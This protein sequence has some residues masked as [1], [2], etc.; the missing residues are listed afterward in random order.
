MLPKVAIFLSILLLSSTITNSYAFSINGLE[1]GNNSQN[2][3]IS[4]SDIMSIEPNF[5][6]ENNFKRYLIFG[7]NLEQNSILK[8][9]SLYGVTSDH[10]FFSV[11][12]LSEQ[13]ASNLITKGYTVIED[14][15]LDFH[16]SN[17][18]SP[19]VSRI[20][21]ITGS[22]N[23]K[24]KYNA[25]GKDIVIAIVDTGVDFSNPDIQHSLAR[26]KLNH[27]I[28]IDP[29]GQGIILTNSTFHAN[30]SEFDTVRNYTK[31]LPENATSSVYLTRDG[32]FLDIFQ[33]GDETTLQV[34]NSL[35]PQFGSSVIFNGTLSTDMKIGNNHRDFIKSESGIYHLGVMYQGALNV[36]SKIQV[37]PV[38]VVD[39]KVSG[40]YDTVIPD[41]STS[42]ED[43]T[44]DSLK[45]NE[46][47]NFDFDFTDETP[48]QLGSGN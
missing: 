24:Q 17:K 8:N 1:S 26:D 23:V 45:N 11:S 4:N 30:I 18:I 32:V 5:L 27:P 28:M 25:T 2:Q 7:T 33:D 31:I 13:T 12:L 43:Y 21:E 22:T 48:I 3:I 19:D 10:G 9:N 42:W 29:D 41:L 16:S 14:S 15:K 38:L 6:V 46:Q 39:S 44:K 47:P 40:V 37:V 35:F 36:S 34:Y 20:G